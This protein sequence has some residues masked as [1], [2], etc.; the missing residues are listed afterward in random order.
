MLLCGDG[1]TGCDHGFHM[2]CLKPP[3][4]AMPE[5]DWFCKACVKKARGDDVNEEKIQDWIDVMMR[6][7]RLQG[8]SFTGRTTPSGAIIKMWMSPSGKPFR[9]MKSALEWLGLPPDKRRSGG[10]SRFAAKPPKPAPPPG[11]TPREKAAESIYRQTKT[12]AAR[13]VRV[14]DKFGHFSNPVPLDIFPDYLEVCPSPQDFGTIAARLNARTTVTDGGYIVDGGAVEFDALGRDLDLVCANSMAYNPAP[15]EGEECEAGDPYAE[16]RKLRPQVAAEIARLAARAQELY[17]NAVV[18]NIVHE[19]GKAAMQGTWRTTPF[20]RRP[21]EHLRDYR[22]APDLPQAEC[23]AVRQV[24]VAAKPDGYLPSPL[25]PWDAAQPWTAVEK[26]GSDSG[27]ASAVGTGAGT[28]TG[29]TGTGSSTG[30]STGAGA[31]VPWYRHPPKA[32]GVDVEERDV[33]GLDCFTRYNVELV[34]GCI[35]PRSQRLPPPARLIFVEKVV[36]PMVNALPAD[37]CFRMKNVAEEIEARAPQI[38]SALERRVRAPGSAP[39]VFR[40][41]HL[42]AAARALVAAV[43]SWPAANFFIHPKGCG[44][45]ARAPIKRGEYIERYLGDMYAPSS[46]AEL[47]RQEDARIIREAIESAAEEKAKAAAEKAAAEAALLS[48]AA[49][50]ATGEGD[51]LTPEQTALLAKH[52][53]GKKRR[54]RCGKCVGCTGEPA[55]ACEI[56]G[57]GPPRR[58]VR[59]VTGRPS[60]ESALQ[61]QRERRAYE[62]EQLLEVQRSHAG[63]PDF[64]NIALERH[65]DD[66]LGF[67]IVYIDA[68][69]AGSFTSRMSHSCDANCASQVVV[70]DGKYTIML[71]ALQDIAVGE[72]LTQNYGASTDSE[73]EYRKAICLCGCGNCHGSFLQFNRH[74]AF[75]QVANTEHTPLHRAARLA[76]ASTAPTSAP[77]HDSALFTTYHFGECV[78]GPLP[79]WLRKWAALMLG[80]VEL[81]QRLLPDVLHTK[82]NL[83]IPEA[84]L[85]ALGMID[86]VSFLLFTVTF[87]ANLAHSLTRSPKHL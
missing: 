31:S 58:K 14:L 1:V 36:L 37:V 84:K 79:P 77:A 17:L 86:K 72:E 8:W 35:E 49:A 16:A 40:E 51:A 24:L 48:A 6:D 42:V 55:R 52:A 70:V 62:R 46:W 69:N 19:N 2:R 39:F 78:L 4:S 38:V 50:V 82:G 74:E 63:L 75:L 73:W 80:F 23:D 44:I 87:Y 71:R 67:G 41:A 30:A 21:Y 28:S 18:T 5:G 32:L 64:Y 3:L 65:H 57:L 10:K 26:A 9:S 53:A 81:E 56:S 34:L 25:F 27:S 33:W 83:G 66:P 15:A 59:S 12:C 13:M 43:E 76:Y 47:E 7:T 22:P 54:R 61:A 45:I 29:G 11:P 60:R 68:K 85:S 20:S